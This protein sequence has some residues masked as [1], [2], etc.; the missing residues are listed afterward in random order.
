MIGFLFCWPSWLCHNFVS[1]LKILIF[2]CCQKKN[3]QK[4]EELFKLNMVIN[5]KKYEIPSNSHLLNK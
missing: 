1:G 5:H 4:F 3:G 2:F